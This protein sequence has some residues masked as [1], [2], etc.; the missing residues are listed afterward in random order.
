MSKIQIK[1]LCAVAAFFGALVLL[2]P[3]VDWYFFK[4][5]TERQLSE[6]A[7]QRPKL[8]LNLGLDLKGGTHLLMELDV[9]KLPAG[10]DVPDAVQRAIEIIRNRVDQF[11]VAEPL[12]AKQGDRWIVVQLPGITNSGQAKELIGKTALLEFRMVDT[13]EKAQN[14]LSKIAEISMPFVGEGAA[15]HISTAAAKLVPVEDELYRGKESSL[16]L[17]SKD[18]PLTGAELDNARVE[19]GGDYGMPVVAFKFKPDAAGKFSNLTA[20]NV[21]KNMAIVLDDVVYSA[22]VI[23]GRIPGGSGVIEGNFAIE[24][25]RNLAIV[26]RAGALPAPVHIIEERTIGP[27]VGEDSIR[28]GLTAT[29]IAAIFIFIFMVV[30]YNVAGLVAD[31]A[32][33]FNILL[34]LAAM[35]YLGSTL[36]LPGIAGIVLTIAI[37]VDDNVLIFERIREELALGKPVRIALETG[38]DK[39]WTAIW[40]SMVATGISAAVLFQFGTGPIKGFAVTLL[41]GMLIGRFTAI[42]FTRLIFQSYLTNRDIQSINIG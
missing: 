42:S 3:S 7:R 40:D 21:G 32:L 24:D 12:I 30:Y 29:L 31:V 19:T 28:K 39:A 23:K 15:A 26:L 13:S 37:S 8:L 1:W 20:A 10:A 33:V 2:W 25:A 11:G 35:A 18:I 16:Y 36:S 4:D 34:L 38:Y 9:A 5:A 17:L 27:T 41:L 14:A 6:A 22:P